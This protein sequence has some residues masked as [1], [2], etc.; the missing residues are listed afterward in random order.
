[1]LIEVQSFTGALTPAR[2]RLV[3]TVATEALVWLSDAVRAVFIRVPS[4]PRAA[5]ASLRPTSVVVVLKDGRRFDA[6]AEEPILA[7]ALERACHDVRRQ[8]ADALGR[9]LRRRRGAAASPDSQLAGAE[10]RLAR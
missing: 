3:T 2:H 1:M 10:R 6:L 8:I 5:P 9:P 7:D 4:G